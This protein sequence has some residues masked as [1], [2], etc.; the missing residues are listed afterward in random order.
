MAQSEHQRLIEA[1]RRHLLEDGD[2]PILAKLVHDLFA[3]ADTE[4][5]RAHSAEEIAGFTRLV[6]ERLAIRLPGEHR[7]WLDE[8]DFA[9]IGGP[10]KP[11]TLVEIITD[12][13]PFLVDSVVAALQD[14]GADID[15]VAHPIVYVERNN[16]GAL[17]VYH[18]T[19][20]PPSGD[21]AIR[22]SLMQIQISGIAGERDRAE[23][24]G[25]LDKVLSDVR[26]AVDDWA[27]MRARLR[28]LIAGFPSTPSPLTREETD[29]AIAFLEWLDDENFTFLGL[30]EYDYVGEQSQG[31]LRRADRPGLGILSDPEMPVLR[32]GNEPTATTPAIREFLTRPEALIVA[33]ANTKSGIHRHVYMDYVGVRLFGKDGDLTG[34]IR[35]VGLFTSTAYNRSIRRIPYLR[36]KAA[37]IIA[38]AGHDLEG[39]SGKA[40]INVLET[41]PRDE[42]FQIDEDTLFDFASAILRLGGRPRV[43]VLA[44]RDEYDR[45]ASVIVFV[46]RNRYDSEIRVRIGNYLSAVFDGWLSA[47]YPV[48]PEGSLVRVHFIIGRPGGQTPNP[49]Q[50]ELE[51]AIGAIIRTWSDELSRILEEDRDPP[52]AVRLLERYRDA[53]PLA[54]RDDFVSDEALAD[55]DRIERLSEDRPLAVE[56]YA[57]HSSPSVGLKLIHLGDPIALSRRVPILEH[58]GFRVIDERSYDIVPAGDPAPV[59]IHD[60]TLEVEGGR[61]IDLGDIGQALTACLMAVWYKNAESDGYNALVVNAGL[62]WRDIALL[63]AISRFLRQASSPYS[64]DYMWASLNRHSD[65]A[66]MLVALF[67]ARFDPLHAD[68]TLA[69]DIAP[70]IAAALKNVESLDED[71]I[72]F[73]FSNIIAAMLRTNFFQPGDNE[74]FHTEINFKLDSAMINEL[75]EPRPFREIFVYSPRVEG[76]H[77]R[78]GEAARG[79]IRW[80]DRP[81]DFRTEVLGLA[82]AQQVKNAVIVPVGAKGGFVPKQLPIGGNRDEVRAE[83]VAAYSIFISSLLDITDDLDGQDLILPQDVVRH[84]GDDPYLVVAADKGTATFSDIANG[85][86]ADHDFWLG[87]AFASGGSVGYDHKQMGITARGAWEAV[88]R[89]FREGDR[90][91]QSEPFSVVGVGDMSGDVFGNGMLLSPEIRLIAAFDHR[92]IFID[93]D[94]D[95]IVS[96]AERRRL[97]DT[98]RSSWQNYDL[99]KISAGGGVFS[100]QQKAIPLS[101]EIKALLDLSADSA[102]P[103]EVMQAILKARADLLWFGGIGTFVRAAEESDDEVGDRAND[104]IRVCAEDLRVMVVGEGANLGMTQNARIEFGLSGG[105]CN[106][107]AIDNSAG[108]NTS[109]VEVNIKI[110]LDRA[111]RT[112]RLGVEKRNE[113]LVSMTEDVADLVLRNNYWQ[114]LAISL[115]EIRGFEDF[116]FQLRMMQGLEARGLLDRAVEVLPDDA[117]M[118]ERQKSGSP[119]TRAEIAVL[120]AY[121][122]IVLF[123]DLVASKVIDDPALT[124]ELVSY[125]PSRMQS[126]CASEIETHRLRREIIANMLANSMI[127]R[128]GP[129]Y[130]TRIADRTGASVGEIAR[131]FVAVRDSFA[132]PALHDEI[133]ALDNLV[134]GA[135]QLEL[136][137]AVQDLLHSRTAWFIRNVRFEEGISPVVTTC[138]EAFAT[139]EPLLSDVLPPQIAAQIKRGA[140]KYQADG[141]PAG[142]AWRIASLP[143]FSDVTDIHLIATQAGS[144]LEIAAKVFFA[145]AGHF[146]ISHIEALALALPVND[147]YDGLALDQ[148]LETLAEA[149]RR[150]SARAIA[151]GE[152]SPF[153]A[154]LAM[155]PEAVEQAIERV[156]ALTDGEA[157][158]VSR[159]TVAA[160]LLADLAEA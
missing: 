6:A 114:T 104:P 88:K 129:S 150:I 13:M 70:E 34:E 98:P 15:L 131:A 123:D 38:R 153:E 50:Q 33:K 158:S 115:A 109:D 141:V 35:F 140:E 144:P 124:A 26:L 154:W 8:A 145:V 2:T 137:R 120:L 67:H 62:A 134:P 64:Q 149:H 48:F 49:S 40:L 27:A 113:M 146:N 99:E 44:R 143:Q 90:N 103:Q 66:A 97:F 31:V 108:V 39:H 53:F 20:P 30:R 7:V 91:I 89:H 130:L 76:V 157:L 19:T 119:L 159:V 102:T 85:I 86:S 54:Y 77:L 25:R 45:F 106:S 135:V 52:L 32:R 16:E 18:G 155:R 110:A 142:L 42:L 29:E 41:Y 58:M 107:D 83:G 117:A 92:D 78:F 61:A 80:S 112:G 28:Q 1:A 122:K 46:P 93:P 82:K 118:A 56:F 47:F 121:A 128:G 68:A 81:Q 95:S 139:I 14:F 51:A 9:E 17:Q 63:R 133:D 151:T 160:N 4:D 69:S 138:S 136:Y 111:V 94:P 152:D 101:E 132:L 59:H 72:I 74:E 100:R 126:P 5:L 147:Y 60:M 55:I 105:R 75:P 148:A 87:D 79:G 125:F 84:D 23:L 156:A 36:R 24:A 65:I 57:T 96:L 12:D 22:E 116:S 127:N 3:N 43:R 37:S 73:S 11:L 21:K 71:R 10:H